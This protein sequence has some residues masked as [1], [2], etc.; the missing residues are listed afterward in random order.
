MWRP[1]GVGRTYPCALGR[2]R[3][4]SG[5]TTELCLQWLDW[6][7]Q[8]AGKPA[9]R[10][11]PGSMAP[12]TEIATVA[13]RKA[14]RGCSFVADGEADRDT[15]HHLRRS[16]RHHPSSFEGDYLTPRAH[17]AARV[18]KLACYPSR[19]LK[20]EPEQMRSAIR[21]L[22]YSPVIARPGAQLRAWTGRPS[23]R[24]RQ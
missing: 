8:D 23:M 20:I 24:R 13:R 19:C 3:V 16:A 14:L 4:A 12:G 10:H 17:R 9:E 7:R 11:V 18:R 15:H 22:T 21:A 5:L 6:D 2:S 1:A